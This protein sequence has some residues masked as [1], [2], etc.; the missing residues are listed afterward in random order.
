MCFLL[1]Q[2]LRERRE[3][4]HFLLKFP[5]VVQTLTSVTKKNLCT[6]EIRKNVLKCIGAKIH[7]SAD[8]L[9]NVFLFFANIKR[10][11]IYIMQHSFQYAIIN[12]ACIKNN[13][14]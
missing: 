11:E 3:I 10:H 6:F 12:S 13:S 4:F 1:G 14:I 9:V 7:P 8:W 5:F 2:N